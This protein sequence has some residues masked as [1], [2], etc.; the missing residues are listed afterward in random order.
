[1]R[2]HLSSFNT[3]VQTVEQLGCKD[4]PYSLVL[5]KDL[6]FDD[7]K[8]I[9]QGLGRLRDQCRWLL[10]DWWAFGESRY[11]ARTAIVQSPDWDGPQFQT[12]ANKGRVSRVFE[13]A[14]SRRRELS[15]SHHEAVAAQPREERERLL[16]LCE[17]HRWSVHRLRDELRQRARPTPSEPIAVPVRYLETVPA[18]PLHIAATILPR[19][20]TTVA[21]KFVELTSVMR[22]I[23]AAAIVQGIAAEVKQGPPITVHDIRRVVALLRLALKDAEEIERKA[24]D[25]AA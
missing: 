23:N 6:A 5:P 7:W 11:G 9:G 2:A 1:M 8:A 20:E 22:L 3:F 4:G 17:Q 19:Q 16:N 18:E 13:A 12:C 14:T 10:G 25:A 21:P 24:E 15:W